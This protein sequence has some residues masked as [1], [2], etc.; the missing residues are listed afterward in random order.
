MKPRAIL[1]CPDEAAAAALDAQIC[2]HL[3]LVDNNQGSRWSGVQLKDGGG[4]AIVWDIQ[5]VK[6]LGD[7]AKTPSLVL[8]TETLN[9]VTKVSNWKEKPPPSPAVDAA[10]QGK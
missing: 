1:L 10:A 2:A 4:A 8:E 6:V 3:R 5:L 9:P 7:P